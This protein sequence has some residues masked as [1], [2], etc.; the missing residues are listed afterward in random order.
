M[1]GALA[2]ATSM[3]ELCTQSGGW[4]AENCLWPANHAGDCPQDVNAQANN[5]T[6]LSFWW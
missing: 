6:D 3:A 5:P 1:E 4:E 2:Q